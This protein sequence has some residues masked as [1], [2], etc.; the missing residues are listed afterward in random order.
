MTADQTTGQLPDG[1]TIR[2]TDT[3]PVKR[4]SGNVRVTIGTAG[5][6][7]VSDVTKDA[8]AS[9][10]APIVA[11]HL[12]VFADTAGTLRDGG[13]NGAIVTDAAPIDLLLTTGLVP[14]VRAGV[15]YLATVA[16]IQN[17]ETPDQPPEATT[18]LTDEHGRTVTN[19]ADEPIETSPFPVPVIVS[20]NAY[21]VPEASAL[22]FGLAADVSVTWSLLG[23][24]AALFTLA[25]NVVTLPLQDFE[26]P[27][28]AD[29]NN[30]YEFTARA[31]NAQSHTTDQAVRVTVT[32]IVDD[33]TPVPFTF[34]DVLTADRSTPVASNTVTVSGINVPTA[35]TVSGGTYSINGGA[36][37]SA[38]TSV[39]SGDTITVRVTSS[40]DGTPVL[41][42]LALGT[43]STTFG[44]YDDAPP[45]VTA[46][47]LA[48]L[49]AT[50]APSI[51]TIGG[52]VSQWSDRS[53]NGNHATQTD[54]DAQPATG[55]RTIFGR[56]ALQFNGTNQ[57][58]ALPASLYLL[59]GT[60][61]SHVFVVTQSDSTGIGTE[62]LV[63][64]TGS[65]AVAVNLGSSRLEFR[66][67]PSTTVLQ[68]VTRDLTQHVVVMKRAGTALTT[69]YDAHTGGS[70]TGASNVTVTALA[71]GANAS[72]A[73]GFLDGLI[74]E[75]LI[76]GA[77]LNTSDEA[78]VMAYLKTKWNTP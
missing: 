65:Y 56:N 78:A 34:S 43:Y 25:G 36:Y 55:A 29:A 18:L 52:T 74:G 51:V 4:G 31:T 45:P 50:N 38:P 39:T 76:Y 7:A 35:L 30:V 1:G 68:S 28:D 12:A 5:T 10:D 21:S 32:N 16:D 27:A 54:P 73:A 57:F 22:S 48:W 3:I 8:V 59:L 62:Y 9:V 20:G 26:N 46:N 6:K 49:D 70:G 58:L 19:E 33:T 17:A 42:T 44:V 69:A 60:G 11:S 23:A 75:I 53:G 72:G 2:A 67:H 64:G 15:V 13:E 77:A 63:N 40:A 47:L 71:I 37:E 24:D 14:I 66:H 41:A 61:P